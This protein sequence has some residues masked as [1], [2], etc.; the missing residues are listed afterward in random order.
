LVRAGQLATA[1]W[2]ALPDFI[3]L[4]ANK[5]G[6]TSM[7]TYLAAHPLVVPCRTKEIN[8]FDR[9][10]NYGRGARWYRSWFPT[11]AALRRRASDQGTD[12]AWTGEATPGYFDVD[13]VPKLVRDTVPDV[14]LIALLREPT[15][16]AWSHYRMRTKGA[17]DPVA[18]LEVLERAAAAG[19]GPHRPVRGEPGMDNLYL[20]RGRYADILDDWYAVFPAEQILLVRSEDM[21]SDPAGSYRRV[22]AHIGLPER[23]LP[24]FTVA[25]QSRGEAEVPG[26][27]REWLDDYYAEPN[28]RLATM[29]DG[30]IVWPRGAGAAQR[31]RSTSS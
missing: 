29:T 27:L 13:Q 21:F 28:R 1:R 22:A 5:G 19:V 12:R 23:V 9:P 15:A 11:R 25:N 16:R 14:R 2:R 17:A 7:L 18:F 4:G 24:A 30:A 8:F 20:Y 31:S 10:W 3:V 26:R 6:T